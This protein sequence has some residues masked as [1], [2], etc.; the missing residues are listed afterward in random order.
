LNLEFEGKLIFNCEI[1]S[2]WTFDE[3][4]EQYYLHLFCKEQPD[5]NWEN[6]DVVQEVHDIMRF[7]LDKG[8]D[9][10]RMDVI[11]LVSKTPGLPDAPVT[12]AGQKYQ[13][14]DVHYAF[15]PRL[16]EHLRELRKVLDEYDAFAVGEMPWVKEQNHVLETVSSSRKELNMIFQFD[17]SVSLFN[18]PFLAWLN[19]E[20]LMRY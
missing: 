20:K 11:N 7:W 1:G 18:C 16:H 3:E 19:T 2:S 17:M 9:G 8:T 10:F 6:P 15:G 5:L 14:A 13:P 4:T 12:L